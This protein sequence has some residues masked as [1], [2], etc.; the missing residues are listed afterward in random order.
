M[1]VF[2]TIGFFSVVQKPGES[3]LTVRSRARAD[4]DRLRDEYLP[5]LGPTT[6]KEGTDYPYRARVPRA[7][8]AIAMLEL[9]KDID[10]SNFKSA[11]ASRMGSARSHVY[12]DVWKALLSLEGHEKAPRRKDVAPSAGRRSRKRSAY[13]GVVVDSEG[14]ILL[15]E[16]TDHYGGYVW[17][18]PKGDAEEGEAPEQAALREV[19]EEAGVAARVRAPIDEWFEGDTSRTKFFL[20][21]LV[22]DVGDYGRETQSV[23]WVSLDEAASL[24]GQTRSQRGRARDLRVLEVVRRLLADG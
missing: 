8:F 12:H 24:I 13:G 7:D 23:R 1:W 6:D 17:T 19:R 20:M 15:R 4:L 2:T 14:R 5:T 10:Y 18:F 21:D 22:E 3:V 16:P 11:V 9:S